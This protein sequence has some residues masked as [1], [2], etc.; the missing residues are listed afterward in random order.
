[1]VIDGGSTDDTVNLARE[2]DVRVIHNERRDAES[3]K[4]LGFAQARGSYFMYLDADIE[5][6]RPRW[7]KKILKPYEEDSNIVGAFTRF[8]PHRDQSW[9]DRCLSY[10]ELHLDPMLEFLTPRI[11]AFRVE[12]ASGYDVISLPCEFQHVL[13]ALRVGCQSLDWVLLVFFR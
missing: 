8:M 12:S 3:A 5:L 4:S 6:A 11:T 9:V 7:W 13:G 2:W 10:Q 1:M